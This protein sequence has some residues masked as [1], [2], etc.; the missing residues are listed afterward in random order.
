MIFFAIILSS[1]NAQKLSTITVN[2]KIVETIEVGNL[3]L[4][5]YLD[6]KHK[7]NIIVSDMKG[8]VL[9]ESKFNNSILKAYPVNGIEEIFFIT[10]KECPQIN[11]NNSS[12]ISVFLFETQT[13]TKKWETCLAGYFF[14]VTD[15]GKFVINNGPDVDGNAYFEIIRLNDGCRIP[16]PIKLRSFNSEWIDNRTV[17]VLTPQTI[18]NPEFKKWYYQHKLN[19]IKVKEEKQV[20]KQRLKTGRLSKQGYD[21]RLQELYGDLLGARKNKLRRRR[22]GRQKITGTKIY[23][24][25][26]VD[27]KIIF[28]KSL[29]TNKGLDFK[30]FGGSDDGFGYISRDN[31]NNI[32]VFGQMEIDGKKQDVIVQVNRNGEILWTYQIR[33]ENRYGV[34]KIKTENDFIINIYDFAKKENNFISFEKHKRIVPDKMNELNRY[35]YSEYGK[36][37]EINKYIK[38]DISKNKV[39]FSYKGEN[40]D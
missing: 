15:N 39:R 20:L 14:S 38:V 32:I 33:A 9:F 18:E 7:F 25:D 11:N 22:P 28:E 37:L 21:L 36:F 5:R 31:K 10:T 34:V 19:K 23:L 29:V 40:N 35:Q 16:F 4:I 24:Y 6:N 12:L 8:K 26:V 3:F 2:G 27:E 30:M 1:I 13:K 17:A